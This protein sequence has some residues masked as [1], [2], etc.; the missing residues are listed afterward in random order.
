[1]AGTIFATVGAAIAL[2]LAA[3]DFG[4]TKIGMSLAVSAIPIAIAI[5]ILH[6]HLYEI[7]VLINR[8]LV[9]G[10]T[11]VGIAVAFFAAIVVLQA[12]L[13]PFT[14]GSEIAVAISTLASVALAQPL[15]VRTQSFVDRRFYRSRYDA[16]RTLDDFSVRLR[17][18]VALD[19]VRTDLL[20]AVR[21]TVQPSYA[22]LWLRPE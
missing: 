8:A 10:A 12:L 19:A 4:L 13:R 22:S 7:D 15:R 2:P 16:A 9:Y 17:D 14:G 6:E 20:D 11:T 3:I 21:D 5:A 1:M 18:Q